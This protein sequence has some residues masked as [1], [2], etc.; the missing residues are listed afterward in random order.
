MIKS[1]YKYN[2]FTGYG[3]QLIN[4]KAD[5]G[6]WNNLSGQR[7]YA[8][9]EYELRQLILDRFDPFQLEK[10]VRFSISSRMMIQPVLEKQGITWEYKPNE[11]N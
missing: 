8:G 7:E 9:L 6:E 4:L 5:P 10:D 11:E 1:G 3:A 2:W